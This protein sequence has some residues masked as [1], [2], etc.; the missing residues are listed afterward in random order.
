ME[1][2]ELFRRERGPVVLPSEEGQHRQRSLLTWVAVLIVVV[3]AA[4]GLVHHLLWQ[5]VG[6]EVTRL[7]PAS[8]G[9]YSEAAEPWEN[10]ERAVSLDRWADPAA[11]EHAHLT[12][13]L[14]ADGL[15][16]R[17]AGVPLALLRRTLVASDRV[18]LTTVPTPEGTA[19]LVFAQI[20]DP[21]AHRRLVGRVA[22]HLETVDRVMGYAVQ[23]LRPHA[24]RLPWLEPPP[25]LR[26]VVMDDHVVVGFGPPEAVEDLIQARVTGRSQ[27][28]ARHEGFRNARPDDDGPALWAWF[29][30]ATLADL[31]RSA[32]EPLLADPLRFRTSIVEHVRAVS[33]ESVLQAGSDL[34]DVR[35][36]TR[37][38][39]TDGAEDEASEAAS[40]PAF[41]G[42][43][44]T[45]I[46]RLPFEPAAAVSLSVTRPG[47]A[48]R[49]ALDNLTALAE[50]LSLGGRPERFVEMRA[51]L[52][53]AGGDTVVTRGLTG[54]VVLAAPRGGRPGPWLLVVGVQDADRGA[55]ALDA[56][57]RSALG[58]DFAY[59][60]LY[61]GGAPVH[62]ARPASGLGPPAAPR[63]A[64]TIRG[65][66]ALV[67]PGPQALPEVGAGVPSEVPAVLGQATR[68]LPDGAPLLAFATPSVLAG[69]GH[70]W[71]DAVLERLR[72][73]F[74]V[75]V[76]A[77]G[78]RDALVVR[79]NLGAWSFA[80]AVTSLERMALNT[81]VLSDLPPACLDAWRALCESQPD[82]FLCEPLEPG[83]EDL[84]RRA[85][86]RFSA[87]RR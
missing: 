6:R 4:A 33:L 48:L 60:T 2:D 32:L 30:P 76:A 27:P 13:G 50:M 71:L 73:D 38:P 64:W 29:D 10:L 69:R 75:A 31:G 51:R 55:E 81:L 54:Q 12:R 15:G 19:L 82:A 74:R 17:L 45:L 70:P 11:L 21:W 20:T 16:G 61:G 42:G 78:E 28:L 39:G 1:P 23:A 26:V 44:H 8:A 47:R 83:R 24:G 5:D 62:L 9:T 84:V 65:E 57:V 43:A 25:P 34:L 79:S 68:A 41:T 67:A 18:R 87:P 37:P 72:P 85:C 14:L 46:A 63:L 7:L 59:G 77:W 49:V 40:T 35:V 36:H 22:P 53:A 58:P 52:L 56:L 86:D 66:V 80:A 3:G